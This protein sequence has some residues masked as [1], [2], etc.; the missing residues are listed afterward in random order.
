MLVEIFSQ[1]FMVLGG[2]LSLIGALGIVRF[3]DLYTRIQA[4]TLCT[5]GMLSIAFGVMI[6][7]IPS[8]L[9][10]KALLIIVFTLLT[11]P[12]ASHAIGRAGYLWGVKQWEKS[13][14]DEYSPFAKRF[15]K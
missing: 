5:L 1:F 6:A 4:S 14:V 13:V 15:R 10:A 9:S 7:S 11:A 12:V 8:P 2:F 3:P